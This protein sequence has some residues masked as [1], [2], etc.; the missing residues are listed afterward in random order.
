MRVRDGRLS[1]SAFPLSTFPENSMSAFNR[2]TLS[3]IPLAMAA[4]S[5]GGG[6][7]LNDVKLNVKPDYIKGNVVST[8]YDGNAND[9]L[10]AGIGKTGLA[11]AARPAP[12]TPASPTV[13]ELRKITTSRN[14]KALV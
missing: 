7:S 11:A 1:H 5:S 10:T 2:V 3:L 9:L 13:E 4:C 8:T 14:Y 12:V 6:G